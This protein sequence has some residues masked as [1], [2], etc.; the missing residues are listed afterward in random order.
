M[1]IF[2][3][4]YSLIWLDYMTEERSGPGPKIKHSINKSLT[5]RLYNF[6]SVRNKLK[7][8]KHLDHISKESENNFLKI[9]R[10]SME[11]YLENKVNY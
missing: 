7:N 11:A 6:R 2:Y 9:F 5:A 10:V 8:K 3:K 1:A 4:K